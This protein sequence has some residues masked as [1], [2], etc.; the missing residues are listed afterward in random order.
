MKDI[1]PAIAPPAGFGERKTSNSAVSDWVAKIAALTT[2]KNIFW[3]DGSEAENDCLLQEATRQEVVLKLNDAKVPHSYLH[4][5]NPNDVARVEQFTFICTPTREEAGPTN[6]WS[7]PR[8]TYDKLNG[9]LRGALRER[10]MFVVPYIMGPPDSP[11]AK[12]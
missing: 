7:D 10:T 2:P 3:C 1:A 9:L 11:L 6:N 4:R 8:E 12:V 5:S